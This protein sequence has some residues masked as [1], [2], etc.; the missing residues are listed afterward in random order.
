M[1]IIETDIPDLIII[2]PKVFGDERGFFLESW[3]TKSFREAGLD[4]SFVQDNHSQSAGGVLRGLHFQNPNPQG[5]LVRV[6]AGRAWDV[7]VDLRRS[8]STF[9]RW[10]GVEL[11]ATNKRMFWV[12]PGFA[13]GFLSLEGGTNLLYKCTAP[14]D[15]A[16]EHSLLWND[17][18]IAI[19]WPLDGKKPQLAARD[20]SGKTF[21]E[22]EAFP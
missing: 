16:N 11:S 18:K 17:P 3:S 10:F 21:D 5:K 12:P 13:H 1:N 7:A 20:E 6:V 9:G 2:E 14:Y 8:S 15:P 4:V 22:I 19:D